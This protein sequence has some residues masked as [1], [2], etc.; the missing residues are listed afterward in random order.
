MGGAT[1]KIETPKM[2]SSLMDPA[3][4]EKECSWLVPATHDQV[5]HLSFYD[6]FHSEDFDSG[7]N[8]F[9]EV[10][11]SGITMPGLRYVT[12]PIR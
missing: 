2:G 3:K 11:S 6:R 7:F 10:R 5:V 4:V 9:I 1:G 8:N 12:I